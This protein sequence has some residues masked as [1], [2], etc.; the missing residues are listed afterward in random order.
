[1]MRWIMGRPNIGLLR[2]TTLAS[3]GI[4]ARVKLGN[5]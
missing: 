5:Q 2:S 1:M 3:M 4:K